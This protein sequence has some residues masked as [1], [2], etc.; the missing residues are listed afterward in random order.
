M[1]KKN[2][3]RTKLGI[4]AKTRIESTTS[5][6]QAGKGEEAMQELLDLCRETEE[7]DKRKSVEN[8]EMIPVI[9]PQE[10]V[11]PPFKVLKCDSSHKSGPLSSQK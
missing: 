11:N 3:A 4:V 6:E 8:G 7:K 9:L 1:A 10:G 2:K 5:I